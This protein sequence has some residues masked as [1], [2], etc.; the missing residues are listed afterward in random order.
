MSQQQHLSAISLTL[1]KLEEMAE[2]FRRSIHEYASL[3]QAMAGAVGVEPGPDPGQQ[4][5]E[6]L[7]ML[8]DTLA[9]GLRLCAQIEEHLIEY[10]RNV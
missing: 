1:L 6:K 9:D 3:D 5:Y 10:R 7:G 2:R 8:G 4:A